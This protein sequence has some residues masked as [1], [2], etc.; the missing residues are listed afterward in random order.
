MLKCFTPR[1]QSLKGFMHGVHMMRS[2]C[3]FFLKSLEGGGHSRIK[4]YQ[5]MVT[6][7]ERVI[8]EMERNG[9]VESYLGTR[10]IWE[11]AGDDGVEMTP[12][13]LACMMEY[14]RRHSLGEGNMDGN[15]WSVVSSLSV[16]HA[17]CLLCS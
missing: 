16:L 5:M 13:F 12:R 1:E 11:D 6:W 15:Q 14:N 2:M 8:V 7:T 4:G 3:C 10:G 9:E 17:L